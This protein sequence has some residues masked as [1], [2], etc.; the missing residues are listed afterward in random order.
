MR[1]HKHFSQ[2]RPRKNL[3]IAGRDNI[4]SA[5]I[6]GV[7]LEKIFLQNDL[8]DAALKKL[9]FEKKVPVNSVPAGKLK[10][11]NIENHQGAI[12][13]RSKVTYQ[14][15]QDVISLVVEKGDAP[16]FLLLDGITDIRN[17]GGLARTAWCCGVHALVIPSKG[18]GML[19]QDAIDTSA[20][21]LEQ[22]SVCRVRDLDEAID[23]LHLNGIRVYGSEMTADKL[24]METNLAEPVAIVMGSEDRGIQPSL[25]KKCDGVFS[26]PMKNN[27][28]SLNVSA[29]TAIILYEGMRQRLTNEHS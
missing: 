5:M 11:F 7:E 8:K 4:I 29:A 14:E 28:E 9:A 18:V 17:I 23:I 21:A 3:L 1:I 12:A 6:D 22:I 20:G 24:L 13:I 19:N 26:I 25:V 2:H 15:L 27:F 16:L 10:S